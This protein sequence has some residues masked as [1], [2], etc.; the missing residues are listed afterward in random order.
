MGKGGERILEAGL[1]F[2]RQHEPEGQCPWSPEQQP[3]NDWQEPVGEH[4]GTATK[5]GEGLRLRS[6]YKAQGHG[7]Q[8]PHEQK[9]GQYGDGQREKMAAGALDKGKDAVVQAKQSHVQSSVWR[10][11]TWPW[12]TDQEE[13]AWLIQQSGAPDTV[14]VQIQAPA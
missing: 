12:Q 8:D 7:E 9:Y 5:P 1:T 4:P 11:K 14:V 2:L 10:K 3:A 13:P 6:T